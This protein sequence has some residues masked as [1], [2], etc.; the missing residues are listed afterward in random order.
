MYRFR[1]AYMTMVLLV[2]IIT[3]Y[4]LF[5]PNWR[6]LA[7]SDS[8]DSL[9]FNGNTTM[10]NDTILIT[11]ISNESKLFIPRQMGIL[12]NRCSYDDVNDQFMDY[13]ALFDE[14]DMIS[15][16]IYNTFEQ[17]NNSD[18]FCFL[19]SSEKPISDTIVMVLLIATS[20][21]DFVALIMPLI[22]YDVQQMCKMSSVTILFQ[23]NL[24]PTISLTT[25]VILYAY[26]N[27]QAVG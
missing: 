7:L 17:R 12:R 9:D 1:I 6:N 24:I 15:G 16:N 11:R 14:N 13:M 25:A 27:K 5:S 19:W 26:S 18:H 4:A 8:Y 20:L 22:D 2:I 10:S 3:N 23:F 21:L